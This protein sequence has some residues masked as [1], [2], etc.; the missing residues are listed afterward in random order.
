[1]SLNGGAVERM[2]KCTTYAVFCLKR[3]IRAIFEDVQIWQLWYIRQ[4][5]NMSLQCSAGL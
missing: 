3:T 2:H 4:E 1:M 5:R